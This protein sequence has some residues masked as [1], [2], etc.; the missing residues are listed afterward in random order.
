M[1][2]QDRGPGV[3]THSAIAHAENATRSR[4]AFFGFGANVGLVNARL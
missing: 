2:H 1:K 4:V 3:V